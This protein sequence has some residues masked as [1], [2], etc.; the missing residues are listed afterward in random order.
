MTISHLNLIS[1]SLGKPDGKD[2]KGGGQR[3]TRALAKVAEKLSIREIFGDFFFI[4]RK[5][6]SCR[7]RQGEEVSLLLE[8]IFEGL[9]EAAVNAKGMEYKYMMDTSNYRG[10]G[11]LVHDKELRKDIE[12]KLKEAATRGEQRDLDEADDIIEVYCINKQ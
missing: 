1:Y 4:R 12:L 6:L 8:F 11:V 7:K 10:Q 5:R 3:V 9:R 2:D